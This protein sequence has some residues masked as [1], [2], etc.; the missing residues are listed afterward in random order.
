MIG[1]FILSDFQSVPHMCLADSSVLRNGNVLCWQ[2]HPQ[3]KFIRFSNNSKT[4]SIGMC[5]HRSFDFVALYHLQGTW[6]CS[7]LRNYATSR[8]VVDSIPD[9]VT[10]VFHWHN[11][12]GWTRALES[13]QPLTGL[14]TRNISGGELRQLVHRA[15]NLTNVHVPTPSLS[16]SL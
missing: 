8:K 16:G 5:F 13:S 14:S 4:S 2:L 6:W 1:I 15:D 3:L 12:S 7:W 9:C 10:A 11:P